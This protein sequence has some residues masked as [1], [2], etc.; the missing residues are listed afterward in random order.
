MP[1]LD[2]RKVYAEAIAPSS[3]PDGETDRNIQ[4]KAADVNHHE[5]DEGED[6]AR[7]ASWARV[8]RW[9]ESGRGSQRR[10]WPSA[11][12]RSRQH[13]HTNTMGSVGPISH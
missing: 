1:C 13:R 10:R 5:N 12:S 11:G 4:K 2:N 7:S 9:M 6:L 3:F 8:P